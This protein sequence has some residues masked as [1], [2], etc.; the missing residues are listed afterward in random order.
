[1]IFPLRG[2]PVILLLIGTVTA[3]LS[4]AE[5]LLAQPEPPQQVDPENADPKVDTFSFPGGTIKEYARMAEAA[6]ENLQIIV[7]PEV[8]KVQVERFEITATDPNVLLGHL[9]AEANNRYH[10]RS[11]SS[12]GRGG[13][14]PGSGEGTPNLIRVSPPPRTVAVFSLKGYAEGDA[15]E[16]QQKVTSVIETVHAALELG[17]I[18]EPKVRLKFHP[19]TELLVVSGTTAQVQLVKAIVEQLNVDSVIQKETQRLKDRIA[20]LEDQLRAIRQPN[21]GSPSKPRG[22]K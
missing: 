19:G 15:E 10:L 7:D 11:I 4:T 6:T 13:G 2:Y 9:A 14:F 5:R 18:D 16:T 20:E 8:E 22:E 1:M 3:W 17:S 21:F 12:D